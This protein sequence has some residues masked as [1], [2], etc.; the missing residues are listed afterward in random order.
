M[1]REP[2]RGVRVHLREIE[3]NGAGEMMSLR[4]GYKSRPGQRAAQKYRRSNGR[5]C[6]APARRQRVRGAGRVLGVEL[7]GDDAVRLE[8]LQPLGQHVG[9]DALE[10]GQQ[11]LEAS[12]PRQQI[13]DDQERPPLAE[14]LERL[15]HGTRLAVAL[16]H[17]PV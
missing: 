3:L 9:R 15:G 12:R 11:I 7:A 4:L 1:R 2:I 5:A 14:E 10:R 17:A 8:D 13:A 16:G 6:H